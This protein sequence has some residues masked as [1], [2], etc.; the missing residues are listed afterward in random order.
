M[1]IKAIRKIVHDIMDKSIKERGF[2]QPSPLQIERAE[3][4]QK[5][6]RIL[7]A[8]TTYGDSESRRVCVD[9]LKIMGEWDE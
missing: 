5:Y 4:R 7:R 1:N 3:E 9:E 8:G 6:I 2:D